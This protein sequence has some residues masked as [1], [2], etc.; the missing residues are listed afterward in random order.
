[1]SRTIQT[2]ML[3]L[4]DRPVVAGNSVGFIFWICAGERKESVNEIR[5]YITLSDEPLFRFEEARVAP[6]GECTS[7]SDIL[8]TTAMVPDT[9]TYQV[10]WDRGPDLEPKRAEL[11]FQIAT[12]QQQD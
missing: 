11:S 6:A 1:M 3:P 10:H 2:G 9:Y 4:G 7:V 5:R 12:P 8:D